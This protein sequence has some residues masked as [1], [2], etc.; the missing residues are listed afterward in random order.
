VKRA[1][2]GASLGAL[3]AWSGPTSAQS[4]PPAESSSAER[5][6][7]AGKAGIA[8]YELG[9]W[10]EALAR[11]RQAETLYHS[12]VFALFAARSLRQ[13]GQ[14][15][16]ARAALQKLVSEAIADTAP[17]A[18][19]KV[20]ADAK[21]ELAELA[22]DM[23]TVTLKVE[24]GVTSVTLDDAPV[25]PDRAIEL[26][27]GRHRAAVSDGVR[28]RELAFD[29]ALRNHPQLL[30]TLREPSASLPTSSVARPAA[31]R[32]RPRVAQKSAFFWSGWLT[33]GT[34]AL[35]LASSGVVGA[36]A[37][38]QRSSLRASL[39][40]SVPEGRCQQTR[41][42]QSERP[43][44][45]AHFAPARRLAVASDVLWISG[46]VLSAAG[47]TLLLLDRQS[48]SQAHVALSLRATGGSLDV[49]F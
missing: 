32:S 11:F 22:A 26:D 7:Q 21:L 20:P 45:D 40:K 28:Q 36:L 10:Q 17:A 34:G 33:T 46:A 3:L 12:P 15:L 23:P 2:V 14:L 27:P 30:L 1:V 48:S 42:L 39:E 5:A 24:G 31:S 44:V 43:A 9:K 19:Q 4:E 29:V 18:W 41:C 38:S 47:I 37:L 13:L 16:E 25:A 35:A 8:A 6:I 49:G